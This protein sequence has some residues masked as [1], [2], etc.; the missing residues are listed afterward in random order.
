MQNLDGMN[1]N[2][3][4]EIIEIQMEEYKALLIQ[5]AS[6]DIEIRRLKNS[7]SET[8]RVIQSNCYDGSGAANDRLLWHLAK[9]RGEV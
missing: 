8:M 6:Y 2:E 5:V 1:K 9:L 7:Q 4:R 3:L